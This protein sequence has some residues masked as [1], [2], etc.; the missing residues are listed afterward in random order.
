MDSPTDANHLKMQQHQGLSIVNL[1]VEILRSVFEYFQRDTE[2]EEDPDVCLATVQS[3]RLVCRLFNDLA[4]PLLL[5]EIHV[6]LAQAS[7]DF[8]A[9]VSRSPLVASGVRKVWVGLLYRPGELVEHWDTFTNYPLAC[10]SEVED[11]LEYLVESWELDGYPEKDKELYAPNVKALTELRHIR[12]AWNPLA[13]LEQPADERSKEYLQILS[14]GRDQYRSQHEEQLRL[15]TSGSFVKDLAAAIAKLPRATS[16]IFEDSFNDGV[17]FGASPLAYSNMA[18]VL[19]DKDV[20]FRFL[21]APLNWLSIQRLGSHVVLHN[22]QAE[23]QPAR[24]LSELPIALHKAGVTLES[25]RVM[26]FPT[27]GNH[28]L[29][30]RPFPAYLVDNIDTM[31]AEQTSADQTPAWND[32]RAASQHLKTFNFDRGILDHQPLRTAPLASEEKDCIDAFLTCFLSSGRLEDSYVNMDAFRLNDGRE[33][34][35][36]YYRLDSVLAAIP[37]LPYLLELVFVNFAATHDELRRLLLRLGSNTKITISRSMD[38]ATEDIGQGAYAP[39][40]PS[41]IRQ[42]GYAHIGRRNGPG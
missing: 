40:S 42:V 24:I 8:A 41:P 27:I 7:L 11:T 14:R 32:L 17:G 21:V 28:V 19:L 35:E 1:P 29:A 20:L 16:L 6:D 13:A 23:L 31:G 39:E 5:P 10:L 2:P 25:L 12:N 33:D 30:V 26:V 22:G 34:V 38:D 15:I 36:D 3:A 9:A 18:Q 37:A 4:S